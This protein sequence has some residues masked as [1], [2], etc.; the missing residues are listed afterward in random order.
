MLRV[1]QP[2]PNYTQ[3][4]FDFDFN[5]SPNGV[6]EYKSDAFGGKLKG[7]IMVVQFSGQDNLLLLDPGSNGDIAYNYNS[8]QGL[9][10]FDDPIEVVEDPNTG[11][12]YVSEYDRDGSSLPQLT[13]LRASD[14]AQPGALIATNQKELIFETTVNDQGEQSQQKNHFNN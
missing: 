3:P 4:A 10:G 1:V 7:L 11:N 6:I 14:P 12:L 9:G 8:V 2:D 5:K 13:L